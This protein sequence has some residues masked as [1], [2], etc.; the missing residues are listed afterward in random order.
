MHGKVNGL[1]ALKSK[2]EGEAI[3]HL[4][5]RAYS[6]ESFLD[7]LGPLSFMKMKQ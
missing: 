5:N 3:W 1:V 6:A 2:V 4:T 7:K